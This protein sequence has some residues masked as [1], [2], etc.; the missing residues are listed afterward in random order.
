[1]SGGY[2][3]YKQYQLNEIADE[4]QELID[5]IGIKDEYGYCYE[6]SDGTMAEFKKALEML[7]TASIY[8]QR[9]DWLVSGDD[10]EETFHKRLKE[11]LNNLT[12]EVSDVSM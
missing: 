7:R 6:F 5:K 9:I 11:E 1:M 12:K 4:L 2:F 3:E 10:G 8:V